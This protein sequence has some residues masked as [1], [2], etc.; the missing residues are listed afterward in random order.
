MEKVFNEFFLQS[1]IH[2][3]DMGAFEI[4]RLS[5]TLITKHFL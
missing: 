2:I 5:V 3:W 4:I 1:I